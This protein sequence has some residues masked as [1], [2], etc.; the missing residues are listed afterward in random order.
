MG[1]STNDKGTF[2]MRVL[3][4]EDEG[5]IANSLKKNFEAVGYEAVIA[6]DGEEALR[7]FDE[8]EYDVLLLDWRMPKV[9]GVEV[10]REIRAKNSNIPIILLTA[11]SDVANKVE[12]LNYGADDYVTKP[13]NYEELIA[14]IEAVVRRDRKAK[15]IIV[16]G[17]IKL[18]LIARKLILN[19]E[20]IRLTER[21]FE[22]LKY[23][24][25]HKGT[26]ISKEELSQK[27]W[28]LP[29]TPTTNFVEATIKNLRKKVEAETGRKYIK[30]I[31]GEGYLF[32]DN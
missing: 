5:P 10:C 20:E 13:F 12:A 6:S 8:N 30:T 18:D 4:A 26:I 25:E 19:E 11:L 15:N 1:M 7:L 21:E 22:L 28:E 2:V 3:I 24:I 17:D 14:R 23:L 9:S 16:I 32:I 27:V 29:F 31:Y